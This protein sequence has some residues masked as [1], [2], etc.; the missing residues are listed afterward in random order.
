MMSDSC[1]TVMVSH[2]LSVMICRPIFGTKLD[3][4]GK[5]SRI[6]FSPSQNVWHMICLIASIWKTLNLNGSTNHHLMTQKITLWLQ[7]KD[8]CMIIS[9]LIW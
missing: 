1:H 2:Y 5:F 6:T 4:S 3:Q 8:I 9:P 7:T